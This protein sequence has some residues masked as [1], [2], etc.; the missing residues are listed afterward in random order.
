MELSEDLL[1]VDF[2]TFLAPLRKQVAESGMSVEEVDALLQNALNAT[3]AEN[4]HKGSQ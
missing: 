4:A 2:D 1:E 3:R